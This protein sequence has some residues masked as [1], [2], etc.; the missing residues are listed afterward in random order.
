MSFSN[1]FVKRLQ[2]QDKQ[3]FEELYTQT[4]DQLYRYVI[5]RYS[6]PKQ[7]ILDV[8]SDFYVKL[9]RVLDQ[10]N[11]DYKFE[12]FFWTVF[13]N[14][15]KDHFKKSSEKHSSEVIFET[16]TSDPDGIIDSI[17]QSFTYEKIQGAM[18][19]LDE[20]SYQVIILRYV[21]HLEYKEIAD[22][23]WV[24]QDA[25]RKRLSRAIG[26]LK[27]LLAGGQ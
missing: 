22:A 20:T 9:R 1:E 21:E 17:Q 3:A 5:G 12:T 18:E 4:N 27:S 11:D 23:L 16:Q 6:L 8:I 10:Y 7:E 14:L 19:E 2:N 26:K 24:K 15:L 13:K 25:I